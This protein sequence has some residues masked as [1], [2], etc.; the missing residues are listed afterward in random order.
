MLHFF[1][2]ATVALV[3]AEGAAPTHHIT[4]DTYVVRHM[5]KAQGDDP[6]LTDEGRRNAEAL[7]EMLADE[8]I[9]AVFATPTRRAMETGAPLAKRLG[10]AV[11]PYDARNPD[12]LVQSVAAAAGPV[13]VVG[14]SN[15][16]PDLVARFGAARPA[17]MSEESYGTLFVVARGGEVTTLELR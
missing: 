1:V 7:A 14:H 10:I 3:T 15:T 16:V 2:A 11:T 5:Q 17:P 13:L 9:V 8:G 4:H 12:S 6:S